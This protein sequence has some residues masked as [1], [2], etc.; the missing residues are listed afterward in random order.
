[1]SDRQPTPVIVAYVG[2]GGLV[3]PRGRIRVEHVDGGFTAEYAAY[4]DCVVLEE[5][6]GGRRALE[7]ID[8]I[9]APTILYDRTADPGLAAEANRVGITEYVTERTLEDEALVDLALAAVESD[10]KESGAS[11]STTPISELPPLEDQTWSFEET[12]ERLFEIG[13]QRL[14]LEIGALAVIDGDEY[15]VVAG[16][17][18]VV[19]SDISLSETLCRLTI[20]TDDAITLPDTTWGPP[21][22]EL[23]GPFDRLRSYIGDDLVV[24]GDRYG[25]VWFGSERTRRAF[26]AGDRAFF[27]RLVDRF[28]AEI[29][30]QRASDGGASE[31]SH[32]V[33]EP[34]ASDGSGDAGI[35][36]QASVT[37][38]PGDP[39]AEITKRA[40]SDVETI[41]RELPSQ[42][43]PDREPTANR[44]DSAET[45]DSGRFRKLFDQ[46]PDAVVDIEFRDGKPI[47]RKVNEAFE[48]TFGY[49][50]TAAIG[51]PLGDL[52]VPAEEKAETERVDETI[53]RD[54]DGTAEVERLGI[55]GRD[56]YLFRGFS[57][58][59]F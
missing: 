6:G 11:H 28:C 49:D 4:A 44:D 37:E 9:A 30:R 5:P 27:Q 19:D 23:A 13:R 56:T 29:E 53:I 36:S 22:D 45:A 2:N 7:A 58:F 38:A 42:F 47:V 12:I 1:M 8:E 39:G 31:L 26:S 17:Q 55:E 10:R 48:E 16:D 15:T 51:R 54:G 40:S 20:R 24:G 35:D 57:Y 41:G 25:T 59:F 14:G 50:E 3:D 43:F 18:A 21:T 33:A 52:I 32:R 46:L 34:L